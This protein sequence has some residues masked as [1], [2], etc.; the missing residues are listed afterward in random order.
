MLELTLV[1]IPKPLRTANAVVVPPGILSPITRQS[2]GFEMDLPITLPNSTA[3]ITFSG[4]NAVDSEI[5]FP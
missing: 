3:S 4:V 2:F 5:F 1:S